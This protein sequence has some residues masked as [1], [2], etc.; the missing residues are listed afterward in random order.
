MKVG[1]GEYVYCNNNKYEGEWENDKKHGQGVYLYQNK[2]EKY[3]GEFRN[4]MK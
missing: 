1:K 3:E 2:G 4:G